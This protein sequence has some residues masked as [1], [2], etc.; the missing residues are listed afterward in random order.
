VFGTGFSSGSVDT[1]ALTGSADAASST[2]QGNGAAASNVLAAIW[3]SCWSYV[4]ESLGVAG[5]C[6][7]NVVLTEKGLVI[8]Q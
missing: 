5:L 7:I 2:V 3:C 1:P 6:V 8:K 4:V